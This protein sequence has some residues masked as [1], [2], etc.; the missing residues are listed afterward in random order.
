MHDNR[1]APFLAHIRQCKTA[2]LPGDRRLFRAGETPFGLVDPRAFAALTELGLAQG[3]E[4]RIEDGTK[5]VGLGVTLA[6]R[7]LYRPHDE[8]F[9]VFDNQGKVIGQ[10]DRGALPLLGCTA[11]GVH[12]N[13]LVQKDG[14]CLIWMGH[15]AANKRLDPGKLDHLAA[16]GI[17]TGLTPMEALIKE[18]GEEA[19]IPP[20]LAAQAQPV[21]TLRYAM[22]RP[23]GLRQDTLYCY[24][25]LLPTE[26][27][28]Q[29]VDGEVA[30]FELMALEQVFALVRDTNDIKF[31]V[32]LVLIDLFLRHGLFTPDESTILR[33]ALD[34][35]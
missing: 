24:D 3:E 17:C 8:L 31:N 23:E 9:D 1:L 26:F 29:P 5:L 30:F 18:S 16:G 12:L 4:F 11:A 6:E 20:K 2:I 33:A 19:A 10:I 34:R 7:G 27:V 32:N 22:A 21:A 28:P 25:L 35:Q 15:R 13:G 14:Q